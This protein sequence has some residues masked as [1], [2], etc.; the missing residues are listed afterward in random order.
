MKPLNCFDR[1]RR[2]PRNVRRQRLSLHLH[3]CGPRPVLEAL[4]DVA[5]GR[6]L[7]ETLEDFARVPVETYRAVG[8]SPLPIQKISVVKGGKR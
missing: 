2:D 6:D 8:A 3:S 1:D 7:D 4:L 5:A